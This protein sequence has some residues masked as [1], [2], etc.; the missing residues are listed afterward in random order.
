MKEEQLGGLQLWMGKGKD[1]KDF[2]GIQT[3]PRFILLD[4]KGNIVD[5]WMTRPSDKKTKET[6]LNLKG[7]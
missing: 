7:I 1:M 2:Y 6:L 3:I 5:A 4:R